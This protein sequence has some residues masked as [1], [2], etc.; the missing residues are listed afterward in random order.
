MFVTL[1]CTLFLVVKDDDESEMPH[2]A[3]QTDS[4]VSHQD[5]SLPPAEIFAAD[6][7]RMFFSVV[8]LLKFVELFL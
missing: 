6:S 2:T 3:C 8:A 4:S 5:G 7:G 1:F